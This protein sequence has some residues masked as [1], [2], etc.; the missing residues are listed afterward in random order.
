MRRLRVLSSVLALVLVAASTVAVESAAAP[1]AAKTFPAPSWIRAYSATKTT[2]ELGWKTVSNA[3]GYVVKAKGGGKTI[4]KNM[5]SVSTARFTGLTPGVKY[6]FT[7]A[8]G[9]SKNKRSK[10]SSKKATRSTTPAWHMDEPKNVKV[11]QAYSNEA[12][13]SWAPPA[14][15]DPAAHN[16]E[17]VA[18]RDQ[19][20]ST[21]V[22]RAYVDGTSGTISRLSSDKLY[23]GR[24]RIVDKAG[25]VLG[26]LSDFA[27]VKTLPPMGAISGKVIAEGG[28]PLSKYLASVYDSS[29][30]L[31]K[32]VQVAADGTYSTSIRTGKYK[33]QI[34]LVGEANYTTMW[35]R[36]SSTGS[37]TSSAAT[38]FSIGSV[39]AAQPSTVIPDVVVGPG[40]VV[41][42]KIVDSN[43]K[44]IK[45]VNVS[46]STSHSSKGDI[47][48]KARTDS[49]GNYTLQGLSAGNVRIRASYSGDG[50]KPATKDIVVGANETK[51][52]GSTKLSNKPFLK[53]Y[54][55]WVDGTKKP[56]LTVRVSNKPFKASTWPTVYANNNR[57]QWYRNGRPIKGATKSY[58]T[59]TSADSG[60]KLSVKAWYGR[61]GYITTSGTSRQYQVH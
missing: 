33:V 21:G 57:Y 49:K 35:A 27:N 46:A 26:D 18:A 32:Q 54:K 56:G 59:I 28:A 47:V 4:E 31:V 8:V 40:S 16:F 41:T 30:S 15:Y 10:F 58:Y 53:Q 11:V 24:V 23:Y 50:F 13:L 36:N 34:Q 25:N 12:V 52:V 29:D 2:V 6:T 51:N 44:A 61:Y 22:V 48:A 37:R 5:A 39:T 42:G 20:M 43:G 55:V 3:P 9:T 45:N 7:I 17:I 14:G 38:T 1:A 60:S 19:K